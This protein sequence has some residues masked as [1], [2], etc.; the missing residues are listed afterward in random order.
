MTNTCMLGEIVCGYMCTLRGYNHDMHT[1][2][3]LP[4]WG[5][6]PVRASMITTGLVPEVCSCTA[7]SMDNIQQNI[8]FRF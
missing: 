3:R 6:G 7:A 8:L 4:L 2:T 1:N 5:R